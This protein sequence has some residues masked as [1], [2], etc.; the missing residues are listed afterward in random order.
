M[1][2]KG[3]PSHNLVQLL[4]RNAQ[5]AELMSGA[6]CGFSGPEE[7]QQK[8]RPRE[9]LTSLS[10]ISR[11]L[12]KIR[13]PKSG[14]ARSNVV[15]L[16]YSKNKLKLH[17]KFPCRKILL[18]IRFL[19]HRFQPSDSPISELDD[20]GTSLLT[21]LKKIQQKPKQFFRDL[22]AAAVRSHDQI[23]LRTLLK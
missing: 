21:A 17:K 5:I 16:L 7:L 23:L 3:V 22:N 18:L 19:N 13:E 20:H 10:Q 4:G 15:Q 6:C 8:T 11:L 9:Q 2:G 14:L 1:G 12:R